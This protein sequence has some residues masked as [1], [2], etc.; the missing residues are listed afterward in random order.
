MNERIS[1][2]T[3]APGAID[4]NRQAESEL[5]AVGFLK[6]RIGAGNYGLKCLGSDGSPRFSHDKGH[7][8][9]GYFLSRA[10][11]GEIS[12]VERSI[13]IVSTGNRLR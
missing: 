6:S 8:F 3:T 12:E 1:N 11:G 2:T 5:R 9:S 7:A 4:P 10:L 13:L